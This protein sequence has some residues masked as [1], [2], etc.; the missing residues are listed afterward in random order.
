MASEFPN[1]PIYAPVP[2]ISPD[3]SQPVEVFLFG[4]H[5]AATAALGLLGVLLCGCR[6]FSLGWLRASELAAFGLPAA[7]FLVTQYFITL[8]SCTKGVLDFPEGLW[9]V[10]IY[11]YA[12]FIPNTPRRAAVVI[13]LMAVMPIKNQADRFQTAASLREA[14]AACEAAGRWS[15]VLAAQWWRRQ[16]PEASAV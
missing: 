1:Y 3:F 7:L 10:L 6:S 11:T 5:A 13:G 12:L 4:F 8:A 15:R 2:F 16:E 9:L 14:L